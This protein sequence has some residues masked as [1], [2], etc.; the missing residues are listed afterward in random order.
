MHYSPN[1]RD[2]NVESW[3]VLRDLEKSAPKVCTP[4]ENPCSNPVIMISSKSNFIFVL[5]Q[6]AKPWEH[7][8]K[9]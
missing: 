2:V 1:S 3:E 4:L 9:L 7:F 8:P 6:T 5:I